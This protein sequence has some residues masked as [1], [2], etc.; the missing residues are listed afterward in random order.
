[1]SDCSVAP[2]TIDNSAA[3]LDRY[4]KVSTINTVYSIILL[5]YIL[6]LITLSIFKHKASGFTLN[7]LILLGVNL[8]S[9][10]A[11]YIL[12]YRTLK[13]WSTVSK[14]SALFFLF[15]LNFVFY[16]TQAFVYWI[17]TVKYWGISLKI[18]LAIQEQDVTK[19]NKFINWILIGGL[20]VYFLTS[21]GE[22]LS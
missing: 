21:I 20:V 16:T 8:S 13:N 5:V 17:F 18:E 12:A 10:M 3:C 19:R 22:A 9:N 15:L 14:G 11:Y 7:L 4:R 6:I 2:A 1:M